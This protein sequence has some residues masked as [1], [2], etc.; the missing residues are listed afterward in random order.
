[1]KHEKLSEAMEHISDRHIAEASAPKK[2]Q[3]WVGAVAAVL[4]LCLVAG[5][6]LRP[7]TTGDP[8]LQEPSNVVLRPAPSDPPFEPL[9]PVEQLSHKYAVS[10]AAYPLMHPYPTIPETGYFDQDA[11]SKWAQDNRAIHNQPLGYADNLRSTWTQLLPEL[12]SGKPGQNTACSPANLYMALAML[13]ETTNG[14]SRDQI[15]R[16]LRADNISA[17]REQANHLWRGHYNN[18]SLNK[19]ILG[20]SLW[21]DDSYRY[22]E[23]TVKL[24]TE[25]YYASVFRGDLAAEEMSVALRSWLNEQTDGLLQNQAQDIS[26][27]PQTVLALATTLCY[28]VQWKNEFSEDMNTQQVF[29]SPTGDYTETFMNQELTYGPYYWSEH[30]GA[31]SLP[32]EDGSE[33][34]LILPDE[35]VSPEEITEEVAQFLAQNPNSTPGGYENKKT[36]RVKL[37]VPKF[38]VSGDLD[39]VETLKKLG[40]TDVFSAKTADF[41]PIIPEESSAFVGSVSHAARVKIDEQGVTAAAYTVLIECGAAMPPTDEVIFTLDRPFMFCVESSAGVPLFAGIVNEP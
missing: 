7:S 38:D 17:L 39:A 19:T 9:Q 30:F 5:M 21:L 33:M 3:L 11:Y 24:L 6:L 22:N 18:D 41:S 29:H 31:I 12:L 37:S 28:Q 23:S 20:S 2:P 8:T 35:G 15:L 13:A 16:L 27:D 34:W 26:F 36:V 14:N 10:L 32:L 40:I 1:M 4:A 25:N